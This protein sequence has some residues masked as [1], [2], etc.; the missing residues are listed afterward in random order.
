M[1]TLKMYVEIE[2][3]RFNNEFS[4]TFNVEDNDDLL[5]ARVPPMLLQPFV[6]KCHTAWANA[7]GRRE[8]LMINCSPLML[9]RKSSSMIMVLQ[10]HNAKSWP[11]FTGEKL[12]AG[13]LE[14]LQQIQNI[15]SLH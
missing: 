15:K 2:A 11:Y 1:E 7:K 14:S 12:T 9:M 6:E 13:M 3:F 10:L 5:D 8:K 4:Y